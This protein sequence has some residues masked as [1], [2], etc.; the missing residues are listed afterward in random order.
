L[1]RARY[2]KTQDEIQCLKMSIAICD[3]IFYEIQRAIRPGTRE[4]DL[5]AIAAGLSVERFCDGPVDIVGCSG[6]NTNP[7][8]MGYS[9]RPIR[10]GDMIF[11]DLAVRY[12]GYHCCYYR[13]FTCGRATRRQEEIYGECRALLY[14][15][16]AQVKAGNTTADICKQW[17]GP[18]HWGGKTWHDTSDCAVGHGIGLD[19]QEAPTITP[20]FSIENP[21]TL[22]E[23]MIIALETFYGS[24][25]GEKPRQGARLENDVLVTRDGYEILT[26]WPDDRITECWI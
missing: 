6:E 14:K 10:P 8:M 24:H 21:V 23:G 5:A 1:N 19:N 26:P 22:E 3:E 16:L 25:P 9:D 12:R 17:P 7:N 2:R 11:V 18:E 20:M 4:S 13:T 15:A